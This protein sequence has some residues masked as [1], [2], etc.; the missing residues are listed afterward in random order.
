MLTRGCG[1]SEQFGARRTCKTRRT[2]GGWG[3]TP[4]GKFSNLHALRLN[5]APSMEASET[6]YSHREVK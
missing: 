4:P 5:L 1:A 2:R 6:K 3:H